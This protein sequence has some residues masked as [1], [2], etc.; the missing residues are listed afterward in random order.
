[1]RS[2]A[3]IGSASGLIA[4]LDVAISGRAG[5]CLGLEFSLLVVGCFFFSRCDD[6]LLDLDMQVAETSGPGG[7]IVGLIRGTVKSVA[8]GESRPG[9]PAFANVGYILGL[10]VAP[11]H[12]RMGIALLLV[13]QLERWFELMG[14]EYAY[15]ATDRSNEASLRLFT[16]RCGYSKFRTPSLLVHPVHSHR[17]RAPRRATVVRLGA[18]DAE[19]LY[20]S[21]F[22]HVEFF[23]ADIGAVL[24]NALS[25]GT[26]LAVVD[27]AGYE[28][29]GVDRFLSSPPA[30]WAVASAWDCGGVFRLE[31]RGA[32]R[33]R[34]GAAAATRALDRLAKWLRV[35]SVPDFFRPFAGWFVY[36]LGGD[37]RDAAVAAEALF[38]SIVN[39]AR[40]AAAAVAVEVAALDP[41]RSRIPHWRRLSCAEDLWCMKRLGGHADG[42]DWARSAPARSI[43]VDPREV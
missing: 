1:M 30:S 24:G 14:T 36:G 9:A 8:T 35:P 26:F 13:R 4:Q 33:L 12:R 17:L 16:A 42:W 3:M 6:C 40:G 20:R 41:L 31:V 15:M 34:R 27:G 2:H 10:R 7:R 5:D 37:G 32:S 21:R 29:R 43:F 25:Q 38:A 22:A 11:S 39:M 28:W 19:R 23:P 18:R